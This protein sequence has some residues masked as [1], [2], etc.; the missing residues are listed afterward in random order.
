MSKRRG[1][2]RIGI[3]GWRY[4]SWRGTFYP[5]GLA[6][7]R[8]LEFASRTLSTIELNGSF[9]SLQRPADWLRWAA[10]TPDEFVF[11]VKGPRYV[12]HMLKLRNARVALANFFAS[13]V[14]ALRHKLGPLLWQ[15]PP[16]LP[17]DEARIEVFLDQLPRDT[18]AAARLAS[19]HDERLDG[20]VCVQ[21]A[22][23]RALRHAIEV[24]HES[25]VDP[26]FI[27]LLR[28]QGV[29]LVVAD[30]AGRWPLLHDQT[31][32]FAYVRLHGDTQLYA[33]G[34][35]DAALQRWAECIDA[36]SRGRQPDEARLAAPVAR[37]R[38]GGARDVFCY[39]DNDAK[40]H[41]P[42]DAARLE[43]QLGVPRREPPVVALKS[44]QAVPVGAT[45]SRR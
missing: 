28:R 9:Y 36:W 8:E 34:Y 38:H 44:M 4:A 16:Q 21:R 33:S 26:R 27:A 22:P 12:T 18:E 31:A 29:A 7:R 23:A 42:F 45:E 10:E 30:T 43:A 1:D 13:G 35:S 37:V 6:Q 17:F 11:A 14:L 25:Y 19:A 20:R 15:L 40:V 39:F 2:L 3:S 5:P 32:D 41:A 24:R